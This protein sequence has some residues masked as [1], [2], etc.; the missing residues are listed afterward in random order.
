MARIPSR[1]GTRL[2]GGRFLFP[3]RRSADQRSLGVDRTEARVK[4]KYGVEL[5]EELFS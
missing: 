3:R 5:L 2:E 1:R 4:A